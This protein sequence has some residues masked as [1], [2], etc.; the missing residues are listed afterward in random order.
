VRNLQFLRGDALARLHRP[1][2]AEVAFAQEI[3]LFPGNREA[4]ASLA[5]L[6]ATTGRSREEVLRVLEAMSRAS[7]G[8]ESALLGAKT[9]EFLG[10]RED[11]ADFRRRGGS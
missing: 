3:Q 5:I 7:P 10:D 1:A 6:Y 9:L 2:E 4:Y 11:A 8:R